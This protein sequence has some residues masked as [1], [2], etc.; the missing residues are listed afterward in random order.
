MSIAYTSVRQDP[1][2]DGIDSAAQQGRDAAH[3][4]HKRAVL[5]HIHNHIAHAEEIFGLQRLSEEFRQVVHGVDVGDG[6][7]IWFSTHSR[8]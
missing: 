3:A 1:P 5:R 2:I 8:T 4:A 7:L 6:D